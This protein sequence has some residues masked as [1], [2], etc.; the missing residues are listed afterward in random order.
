[1]N[2]E[3]AHPKTLRKSLGNGLT[4]RYS[5]ADDIDNLVEFNTRV[6]TDD[7]TGK[8]DVR[9]GHWTRDLLTLHNN[10]EAGPFGLLIE[11]DT[12][13]RVASALIS[14]PQT[15]TFAGIPV[16][17]GRPELVG[18]DKEFRKRGLVRT[19]F[20]EFHRSSQERGD[21]LQGITGIPYFYRQFGYEMAVELGGSYSAYEPQVKA[22]AKVDKAGCSVRPAS[23]DDIPFLCD[24]YQSSASRYLLHC[25]LGHEWWTTDLN[26]KH[27][28]NIG[29][30][31][32]YILESAD[33][34]PA[35]FFIL[36]KE[37]DG[38]AVVVR[39]VEVRS[40]LNWRDYMPL[41]IEQSWSFGQELSAVLGK[42][43]T[44]LC[45]GLGSEHP[46]Y[47]VASEYLPEWRKPY[48]WYLR[49]PDLPKLILHIAPVIEKRIARSPFCGYT[50]KL[51]ICF[52]KSDL[53]LEFQSGALVKAETAPASVWYDA[54]VCFPDLT[55]LQLL[56][57]YRSSRELSDFF[58]DCRIPRKYIPLLDVIF[59]KQPSLILPIE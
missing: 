41:M 47:Q 59:P 7:E 29:K 38:E 13:H 9:I 36:S 15:W 55:F 44:R 2:T 34:Q 37:M 57:G 6:L 27:P 35:G 31:A 46:A 25:P 56:F 3:Q 49:V 18:T 51:K 8:P 28:D 24:C 17:V 20:Q 53:R 10:E 43:C 45:V 52:Y 30:Q 5:T 54:D 39:Y 48:N 26:R 40:G 19:L 33:K 58:A 14:I 23:R 22:A 21:L 50:G 32:I 12:T 1:M 42:T 16:S 11:E 4:L